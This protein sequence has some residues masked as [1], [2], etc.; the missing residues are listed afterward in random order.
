MKYPVLLMLIILACSSC[1]TYEKSAGRQ[2]S[3]VAAQF[4]QVNVS[5]NLIISP[6]SDGKLQGT[7]G[8]GLSPSDSLNGNSVGPKPPLDIPSLPPAP[9]GLNEV[10]ANPEDS[11]KEL[12]GPPPAGD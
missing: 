3:D 9:K 11:P 10:I 1:V 2:S 5:G 8:G 4:K 6:A 7:Q 12:V